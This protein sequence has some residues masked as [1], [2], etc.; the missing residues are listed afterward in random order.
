MDYNWNQHFSRN[1]S[2]FQCKC[3]KLWFSITFR[4]GVFI[5]SIIT[6]ICYDLRHNH[7]ITNL[8]WFT[9]WSLLNTW[10]FYTHGPRTYVRRPMLMEFIKFGYSINVHDWLTLPNTGRGVADCL[11]SGFLR[12]GYLHVLII[13]SITTAIHFFEGCGYDDVLSGRNK[14]WFNKNWSMK[15][16]VLF[17]L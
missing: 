12:C 2:K 11:L 13:W 7:Y 3:I 9:F 17:A 5:W 6:M 8:L 16:Q 10:M 1:V 4:A 14:I 15:I